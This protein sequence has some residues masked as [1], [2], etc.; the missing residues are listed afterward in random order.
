M[1]LYIVNGSNNCRKVQAV[2]EN[3]GLDV[4]VV[5]LNFAT[6]DLKTPEF[7]ALNPNG[8]VP[9]LED[10]DYKLWE[11]NAIMQYLANGVPGNTLYPEDPR[12][13]IEI[14]RWQFW[15]TAHYNRWIGTLAFEIILKPMFGMGDPDEAA[16]AE[17]RGFFDKFA[18]VI[19]V[20]LA[21]SPYLV[22]ENPPLADFSVGS[23]AAYVGGLG[24]DLNSHANLRD[25]YTRLDSVAGWA[26]TA[27]PQAA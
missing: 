1:K 19:D 12:T 3:L 14:N 23:F 10:G 16:V 4:E 13:R 2:I 9:V 6:G 22:G 26:E 24:L 8:K 25:L 15:E 5:E 7:H 11:S 18:P 17:A 20:Q 21:N 27:P